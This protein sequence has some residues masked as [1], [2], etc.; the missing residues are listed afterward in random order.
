MICETEKKSLKFKNKYDSSF[1]CQFAKGNIS[2]REAKLN[3]NDYAEVTKSKKNA[4]GFGKNR[5]GMIGQVIGIYFNRCGTQ[6]KSGN[7]K[8]LRIYI[9]KFPDGAEIV[10]DS[11]QLRPIN[12]N[13]YDTNR[14]CIELHEGSETFW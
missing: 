4:D 5:V 7:P 3:I 14:F 9:V 12:T 2:G 1:G 10:F 13:L 8:R 6:K 11:W